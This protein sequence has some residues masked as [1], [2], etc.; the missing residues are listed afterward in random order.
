MALV[1][2]HWALHLPV[3]PQAARGLIGSPFT[4]LHLPSEPD[5]L[6]DWHWPSHLPS[7][8]TPSTQFPDVHW[9]RRRAACAIVEGLGAGAGRVAVGARRARGRGAAA[10]AF[11]AAVGRA[12]VAGARAG[13]GERARSRPV[14]HG[15]GGRLAAR[16]GGR[17]ADR[18]AVGERAR[19]PVD[20]VA[21]SFAGSR[22]ATRRA[23]GERGSLRR[24]AFADR[25][26]LLARLA[27]SVALA[28]AA[29]AV[30]AVSRRTRSAR[31]TT[32]TIGLADETDPRGIAIGTCAA[33]AR[34][35][36]AIAFG[37]RAGRTLAGR[38]GAGNGRAAGT[39]AVANGCGGDLAAHAGRGRAN[40]GAVGERAGLSVGAV[41]LARAR[42][43]AAT[44]VAWTNRAPFD[45]LARAWRSSLLARLALAIAGRIT[46]QS[47][48][49]MSRRTFCIH[50]ACRGVRAMHV[51]G[52]INCARVVARRV[53][54]AASLVATSLVVPS[55]L[56]GVV[57]R[58]GAAFAARSMRN[59]SSRPAGAPAWRRRAHGPEAGRTA[60]KDQHGG[61]KHHSRNAN[62][63]QF[64]R[65]HRDLLQRRTSSAGERRCPTMGPKIHGT[66]LANR[67]RGEEYA[68]TVR[69]ASGSCH[70]TISA[71]A[72]SRI[73]P[74][75]YQHSGDSHHVLHAADRAC[76][77]QR[78]TLTERKHTQ[79]WAGD[80]R[81]SCAL[82]R[83]SLIAPARARRAA[84]RP[85][86]PARPRGVDR[87]ARPAGYR[88][89]PRGSPDASQ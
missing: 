17:R 83:E 56:D 14:A 71:S 80:R 69:G 86:R 78:G 88:C 72:G 7:Q 26:G 8:Q 35:A 51:H 66:G 11:A 47:V 24:S 22:S 60:E 15:S 18:A 25:A 2:S 58:R 77:T 27:L 52:R 53:V 45:G 12:H 63:R 20:S 44:C 84:R 29:D 21:L 30:D 5:S 37:T 54:V 59:R 43:R 75:N 32:R 34:G 81:G 74:P 62:H 68:R 46:A 31:R 19:H 67:T 4:V 82:T 3:P 73:L 57:D 16:A 76:R 48:D 85:R 40:R 28:I 61:A 6:H 79:G 70:W 49:A 87:E 23:R 55:L 33:R 50:L 36:A 38:A 39:D 42:S 65:A 89:G 9:V 13:R 64:F 1:P 41:T 10:R